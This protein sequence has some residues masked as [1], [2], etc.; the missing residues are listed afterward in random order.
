MRDLYVMTFSEIGRW[1]RR[2][3]AFTAAAALAVGLG[4]SPALAQEPPATPAAPSM[5]I[6]DGEGGARAT[7]A[8]G[9]MTRAQEAG[10]LM[11][12]VGVDAGFSPEGKLD[13]AGVA[14]QRG[15]ISAAQE[16]VVGGLEA[17]E[18]VIRFETVPFVSMVIN[19]ADLERLLDM[20]GITSIHEDVPVPP[21]LN[22]STRT[23]NARQVWRQGLTGNRWAVAVLDTGTQLNHDAFDGAI[24]SGACF[25]QNI[26]GQ[27]V[28]LCPSGRDRQLG[29][30]AGRACRPVNF[31]GC[32]HGTHVAGIAMGDR[33]NRRGVAYDADLV[34]IQVFSRFDSD[35]FCGAGR[36]PCVLAHW[37]DQ[38]RGLER[39]L[40]LHNRGIV[41]RIAAA[42]MSLGGGRHTA[43]CD[44]LVPALTGVIENLRSRGI[45]TVIASGNDGF[46]GAI[47]APAC[48]S[49]AIAVG[50]TTN[51]DEVSGFS[52]HARMVDLMAPGS[53]ISAP[54]Y[55]RPAVTH[56][57][58]NKS[59]TSMATPHVAGA[60]AVLRQAKPDASVDEVL[61]ALVCTGELV[62]RNNLPLPRINLLA[63][64]NFLENPV[65]SR[66]WGFVN[67]RQFR[68]WEQHLG[69]WRR[70]GNQMRVVN[71]QP[72]RWYA[73]T[74]P[75]CARD[76][77]VDATVRRIDPDSLTNWNSGL[78]LFS[79]IDEGKNM[80]GMWFAFNKTGD[81]RAV[82]WAMDNWNGNTNSGSARLLCNNSAPSVNIGGLNRLRVI[83]RGGQHRFLING[84]EVCSATETSFT[85]G[86]VAV[87]MAGPENVGGHR[88]DVARVTADALGVSEDF[89]P[90]AGV[91]DDDLSAVPTALGSY[92]RA[93]EG[94]SLPV[95]P[96]ESPLG[97]STAD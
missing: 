43:A 53:N 77:R 52:N 97:V 26:A 42:N 34:S 35:Q 39:V 20:P 47:G 96:G 90:A 64:R 24:V 50:S 33:G 60:W 63:A 9:L 46:N 57:V 3:Q 22:Q 78:F 4:L 84:A 16:R 28:S 79:N 7:D 93:P 2:A 59:G 92:Q 66:R 61:R 88:Y 45:A 5:M 19:P 89:G 10:R 13:G 44:G 51:D 49:S 82:I 71:N 41:P 31:P 81:G 75:F 72:Q 70:V 73:A 17:P 80:S 14:A 67:D 87:V 15:G 56:R 36:A 94:G 21:A 76:V 86:D 69:N 1:L 40:Q 18:N 58:T 23:I 68:Q 38:V 32:D 74:S 95:E 6:A 25:S 11:V 54:F 37:T 62:E 83:S 65:I 55:R 29:I 91:A 27:S 30:N 8:A 48:I 85:T 12:I